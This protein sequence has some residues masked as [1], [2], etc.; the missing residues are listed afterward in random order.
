V[1]EGKGEERKEWGGRRSEG[2]A[3][4]MKGREGRERERKKGRGEG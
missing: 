4:E 3:R 2:E 1:R